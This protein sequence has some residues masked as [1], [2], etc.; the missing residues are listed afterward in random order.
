MYRVDGS[1]DLDEETLDHWEGYRGSSPVRVGNG[2]VEQLQ[3]DIYGEALD[4]LH[5][6]D[7]R[8]IELGYDSWTALSGILDW[9]A[10]NW[11]QPE[12]GIWETRGGRQDFTYGRFMCWVA[13]DRAIRLAAARGRPANF[14]RWTDERDTI[15]RQI[16]NRGWNQTGP[17]S[18]STTAARCSTPRYCACPPPASSAPGTPGG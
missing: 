6:A 1:T 9:V 12:E 8:G 7:R 3:L 14:R 5:F 16:M 13:L 11:D 18:S 15:Y 10:E 17:P 2:A 4:C